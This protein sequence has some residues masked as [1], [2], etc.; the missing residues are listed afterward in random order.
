MTKLINKVVIVNNRR[1]SMRLCDKE[2]DA[3]EE[4]CEKEKIS[5]NDL[6]SIIEE[7]K[8]NALGL[9]YSARLFVIEYFREAA[10]ADGHTKAKHEANDNLFSLKKIIKKALSV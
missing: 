9:T 3:F 5:K 4:I 8:N 6:L 10:T 2:W 7:I 1:T